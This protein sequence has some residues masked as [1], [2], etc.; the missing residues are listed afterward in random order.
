MI[1]AYACSFGFIL[2]RMTGVAFSAPL[3]NFVPVILRAAIT[4]VLAIPMVMLAGPYQGELGIS[5]LAMA[6]LGEFL[7]GFTLGLLLR[8]FFAA[9]NAAG[10]IIGFQAALG[11]AGVADPFLQDNALATTRFL[12]AI[13]ALA[14]IVA[15]GMEAVFATLAESIAALPPGSVM[16]TTSGVYALAGAFYTIIPAACRLSLP[17]LAAITAGNLVMAFLAR[18]APT[19]QLFALSLSVMLLLAIYAL[20]YSTPA[21]VYY[22]AALATNAQEELFAVMQGMF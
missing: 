18:V 2:L 20:G 22:A 4:G 11:F 16:P 5:Y 19:L 12:F 9:I 7:F 21:F 1:E 17:V 14:F 15:G 10:Q 3:F 13:S 8:M 6:I